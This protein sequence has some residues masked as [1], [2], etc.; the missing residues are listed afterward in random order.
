[1]KRL[2]LLQIF[3]PATL[4]WGTASYAETSSWE[5]YEEAGQQ[6][7]AKG[8]YEQAERSYRL[9]LKE[10]EES[11]DKHSRLTDSLTAFANVLIWR[12]QFKSAELVIQRAIDLWEK[13]LQSNQPEAAARLKSGALKLNGLAQTYL[14]LERPQ[15]AQPLLEEALTLD[16]DCSVAQKTQ[17]FASWELLN[18]HAVGNYSRQTDADYHNSNVEKFLNGRARGLRGVDFQ[19]DD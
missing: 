15:D 6:A 11:G 12:G 1:M 3:L 8:D 18:K 4:V 7:L 17:K 2:D 13:D 14:I 10:A 9:A 5:E 19:P 16:P